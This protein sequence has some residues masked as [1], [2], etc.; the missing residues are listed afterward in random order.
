MDTRDWILLVV[1]ILCN[2]VIVFILQKIFEK[3]QIVRTLKLDYTSV[4]VKKIDNSLAQ[5]ARATR[6]NNE[7]NANNVLVNEAIRCYV[8][9]SLDTYYY[10]VANKNIFSSLTTKFDKL[11]GLIMELTQIANSGEDDIESFNQRFNRIRD[12]L[13]EIKDKCIKLKI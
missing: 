9:S 5:H 7:G 3:R 13:I 11:A 6:L 2:G 8:D 4:L 10:F 1:P 12:V